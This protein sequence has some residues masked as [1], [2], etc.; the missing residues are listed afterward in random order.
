MASEGE[1][2][3]MELYYLTTLSVTRLYRVGWQVD[4]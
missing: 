2:G 1:L 3:S 4:R